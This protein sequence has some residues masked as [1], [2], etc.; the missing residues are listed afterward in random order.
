MQQPPVL[1]V[2]APASPSSSPE[3]GQPTKTSGADL[4]RRSIHCAQLLGWGWHGPD[5]PVPGWPR[6]PVSS[7]GRWPAG[8]QVGLETVPLVT[9]H[10]SSFFWDFQ[11][12]GS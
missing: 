1:G 8:P 12:F 6:L 2:E 7:L 11:V 9:G 4:S 5:S 10:V 3:L